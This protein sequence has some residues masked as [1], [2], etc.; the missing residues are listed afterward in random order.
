MPVDHLYVFFGKDSYLGLLS[1]FFFFSKVV[2]Y[3]DAE[4]YELFIHLDYLLLLSHI[5]TNIFSHSVVYLFVLSLTSFAVPKLLSLI[6]SCLFPFSL[7]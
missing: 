6:R 2:C 4:L 7:P 3:F 1:I 5:F